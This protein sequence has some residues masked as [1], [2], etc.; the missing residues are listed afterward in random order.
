M[1]EVY[2]FLKKAGTYYLATVEGDQPRVRPFGTIDLFEDKL[3]IHT[4]KIKYSDELYTSRDLLDTL[5]HEYKHASDFSKINRLQSE[6]EEFNSIPKEQLDIM[7]KEI[8]GFSD[9]VIFLKKSSEKG[10]IENHSKGGRRFTKLNEIIK[11]QA[12]IPYLD[13]LHEIRARQASAEQLQRYDAC[14]NS[15][16]KLFDAKFIPPKVS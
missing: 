9:A 11:N 5:S 10:V 12:E 7:L 8:D 2:E 14:W 15:V 16:G 6:I 1:K 4:G 3:Y 13:R